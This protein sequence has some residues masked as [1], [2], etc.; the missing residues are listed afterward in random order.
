MQRKL[1]AVQTDL[2]DMLELPT[3]VS[4]A[5]AMIRG[6]GPALPKVQVQYVAF[7]CESIKDVEKILSLKK[8]AFDESMF[9]RMEVYGRAIHMV[10]HN[11]I[12]SLGKEL[13]LQDIK[14]GYKAINDNGLQA[15][16][17]MR[18]VIDNL[19]KELPSKELLRVMG[20][21]HEAAEEFVLLEMKHQRERTN[22]FVKGILQNNECTYKSVINCVEGTTPTAS[23]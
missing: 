2:T 8:E 23:T 22:G 9:P 11:A 16:E 14:D 3:D 5:V 20:P 1:D 18:G 15:M 7:M 10:E 21:I 4:Y 6:K 17:D 19:G 12:D 13:L